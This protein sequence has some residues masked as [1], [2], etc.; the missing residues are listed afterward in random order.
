MTIIRPLLSAL[1]F[2]VV[3]GCGPDDPDNTPKPGNPGTETKLPALDG[4][5][6][7]NQADRLLYFINTDKDAPGLY[8]FRPSTP[9]TPANYVDPELNVITPFAH[10][11][12]R[13]KLNSDGS[14]EDFHAGGVFYNSYSSDSTSA[15]EFAEGHS[16]L[17]SALPSQLNEPIRQVSN[18]TEGAALLDSTGG[19]F[20]FNLHALEDSSFFFY[21]FDSPQ[22]LHFDMDE[23]TAP[24]AVEEGR[25]LWS[26]LGSD[27]PAHEH[28]IFVKEDQGALVT[29]DRDFATSFPVIDEDTQ[30]PITGVSELSTYI[31]ALNLNDGLF[32]LGFSADNDGDGLPGTLYRY[33][34]PTTEQP[35]G[36][37]KQLKNDAGETAVFALG[38]S[39]LGR[40]VPT[41]PLLYAHDNQAYFADGPSMFNSTWT[42]FTHADRNSWRSFDHKKSLIDEGKDITMGGLLTESTGALMYSFLPSVFIPVGEHGTFWAPGRVPELMKATAQGNPQ[43]WER[44]SLGGKLPNV[45]STPI[46]NSANGWVFYNYDDKGDGAI[47]YHVPSKKVLQFPNASWIGSSVTGKSLDATGSAAHAELSEVFLLHSD[48]RLVALEAAHPDKGTVLLGTLPSTTESVTI[49]VGQGPHRLLRLQHEDAIGTEVLYVD[50]QRKG[51]LQHLMDHPAQDWKRSYH[52]ELGGQTIDMSR[53]VFSRYTQPVSGF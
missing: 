38:I 50:T 27:S 9:D 52:V 24:I 13:G 16:L 44:T 19:L 40:A 32:V 36:T 41:E 20:S 46:I 39:I 48:R 47:A 34:R 23:T 33:S 45:A 51:S 31:G 42:T 5:P 4:I 7:T 22:M 43:E 1:C 18:A 17:V 30:L 11:V 15:T 12:H 53:D 3:V 37:A 14:I 8:A 21:G 28:F 29:Y 35:G 6:S 2:A 10:A 26:M 25:I 49:S